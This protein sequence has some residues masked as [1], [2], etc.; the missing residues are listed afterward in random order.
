MEQGTVT[1][2]EPERALWL[3][4]H[5]ESTWN[6][7]GLV[8]GQVGEPT[9]TRQGM[10]QARRVA[11]QL[12]G[13]QI[14]AV[15]SSDLQRA[16]QTAQPVAAALGLDMVQDARLRERS[17][18]TAEGTPT[19][20]LLLERSGIRDGWVVDPDAAPPAGESV[21]DLYRRAT[22]FVRAILQPEGLRDGRPG[23]VVLVAHGGVVR[24][25]LAWIDGIEPDR[26]PWGPIGNGLVVRR[27]LFRAPAPRL[28]ASATQA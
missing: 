24:V 18:G 27:P 10:A 17:F 7:L 2:T 21:R 1:D 5:G 4:R 9:L 26:M 28:S 23:D 14:S 15:Y 22:G 3:V 19:R 16:V 25:V 12:A 11:R 13:H 6:A 20:S 8:Q